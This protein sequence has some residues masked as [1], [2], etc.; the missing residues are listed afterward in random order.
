MPVGTELNSENIVRTAVSILG[1]CD[2]TFLQVSKEKR[3]TGYRFKYYDCK[4]IPNINRAV[5]ALF[6]EGIKVDRVSTRCDGS[7]NKEVH[8]ICIHVPF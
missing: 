8:S 5:K 7:K 1:E 4:P 3:K 6:D 2:V